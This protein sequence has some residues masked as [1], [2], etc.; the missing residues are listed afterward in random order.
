MGAGAEQEHPAFVALMQECWATEP[1][2]RPP[3]AAVVT[4]LAAL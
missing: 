4:V 1:R 2:L 3:F